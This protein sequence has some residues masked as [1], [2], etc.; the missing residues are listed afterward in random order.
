MK[1]RYH[2]F[3]GLAGKFNGFFTRQIAVFILVLLL[4]PT[5]EIKAQT[6]AA[7]ETEARLKK[8]AAKYFDEGDF[9]EAYPLYSQL[10]S[11]YPRD[12]NY[13]Y[14]FG[15]CML[16]T[17]A[18]KNKAVD[19]LEFAVKQPDVEVLAYYY[20]GRALHLNYRFNEAISSYQKFEDLAP[21]SE[22]KKYPVVNYIE[23]CN[24]GRELIA[25]LR[26]LDVLR[27]KELKLSDYFEAYDMHSN[28]GYLIS[29]PDEF[30]SKIDKNKSNT[31]LIYL[32]PDKS[33][34]F[35]SSYGSNENNGKDI[36]RVKRNHNG[37]WSVPENLGDIINTTFDED[38]PVYDAPHHTLYFSSKGHNTMGG[39]DIFKSVYSD[40]TNTFSEPVNLDFPVN[41]P[42]D[43]ILFVPDSSGQTAFFSSTRSSPLGT[44][45]VYKIALHVHPPEM[46]MIAGTA[47]LDDG[48]TPATLKITV[49]DIKTDS[50][51]GVYRSSAQDGKYSFSIPNGG[52]YKFTVEDSSHKSQSQLVLLPVSESMKAVE[53]NIQFSSN[54]SV[55]I[56]TNQTELPKDSDYQLAY[57]AI[58]EQ[59]QMNVNVDTN[60]LQTLLA[61]NSTSNPNKNT[62]GGS[63]NNNDTVSGSVNTNVS[64]V[65]ELETQE[66]ALNDKETKAVDFASDKL[67][68][69]QQQQFEAWNILNS[70]KVNG[71]Q[72]NNLDSIKYAKNLLSQSKTLEEKGL[73]AYQLAAG[74]K[75]A[76]TV[77]QAEIEKK[78]TI[79]PSM[80]VNNNLSGQTQSN[81]Q[82]L[83]NNNPEPSTGKVSPGDLIRKQA[84]QVQADSVEVAHNTND[85][86][87]EVTSLQQS[88]HDFITQA[89]QATD[90][91][92]KVA[93]LHQA[94]DLTKSKQEKEQQVNDNN[95]QLQQ[96]HNEVAWLNSR[97]QKAD[98]VYI[99]MAVNRK[100]STDN[101][102]PQTQTSLQKEIDD[103]AANNN[104]SSD[105]TNATV[106]DTTNNKVVD[107]NKKNNS[108]NP[109]AINNSN[110]PNGKISENTSQPENL[111]TVSAQAGNIDTT[112]SGNQTNT[113]SLASSQTIYSST[114]PKDTSSIS[115]NSNLGTVNNSGSKSSG[116]EK[117]N[118]ANTVTAGS[119]NTIPAD[120]NTASINT[121]GSTPNSQSSNNTSDTSVVNGN[122]NTKADIVQSSG[123]RDSIRNSQVTL[124]NKNTSE[125]KGNNNS[126]IVNTSLDT[127]SDNNLNSHPAIN[128]N[129][130]SSFNGNNPSNIGIVPSNAT[131]DS[132]GN[133]QAVTNNN[134]SMVNGSNNNKDS[135][136]V[137]S[138]NIDSLGNQLAVNNNNASKNTINKSSNVGKTQLN[139][140]TENGSNTQFSN[141]VNDTSAVNGNNSIAAG[142]SPTGTISGKTETS[143]KTNQKNNKSDVN[144]F[145][146]RGNDTSDALIDSS[147]NSLVV[148]NNNTG[149]IVNGNSFSGNGNI[150]SNSVTGNSGN[151]QVTNN[152]FSAKT[153]NGNN[154][155][156]NGEDSI[157]ISQG[158][159]SRNAQTSNSDSSNPVANGNNISN[160][161]KILAGNNVVTSQENDEA[162]GSKSNN[163]NKANNKE[164]AGNSSE[165]SSSASSNSLPE[166]FGYHTTITPH[167][168]F[169]DSIANAVPKTES[170]NK[171][172]Q[173]QSRDLVSSVQ[174]TDTVTVSLKQKS[175]NYF[176]AATT[177]SNK[178]K[179]TSAKSLKEPDKNKS[180][181]LTA[182]ADSLD[183]LALQLNLKGNETLAEADYRQYRNNV[184]E[185][186][187]LDILQDTSETYKVTASKNLIKE[188]DNNYK[189]SVTQRDK[190]NNTAILT[191]KHDDIKSARQEL[192]TAIL[193]QQ[194][195]VYL[196]FQADSTHRANKQVVA[197]VG[198]D[199]NYTYPNF[200]K[201][202]GIEIPNIRADNS[203]Q[204]I[205]SVNTKAPSTV[206]Q[207]N[208]NLQTGNSSKA[209][210]NPSPDLA[211]KTNLPLSKNQNGNIVGSTETTNPI[212]TS[213]NIQ[214]NS[215]ASKNTTETISLSD[216]V[217]VFREVKGSAYSASH[218]I[219]LNPP[220]PSGLLFKVQVGAFRKP[221]PQNLFEGIEPIIGQEAPGGFIRY[222]TGLFRTFDTAKSV[223][224]KV[225]NRGYSDA[226]IIAFFNGERISMKLA[227]AKLGITTPPVASSG[228]AQAN[229]V[230]N[231][232]AI[233]EPGNATVSQ[234]NN[235]PGIIADNTI[236]PT[237]NTLIDSGSEAV[238]AIKDTVPPAAQSFKEIKGLV[239][240]VQVGSFSKHKGF[241]R[242]RKIK[243]L[244]SWDDADGTV[245][246]NSGTYK[247]IADAKAAKGII[248]ANT[249][250]KDAFI[251][252]YYNGNRISIADANELLTKG[253]ISTKPVPIAASINNT[254]KVNNKVS[255]V[256]KETG[257]TKDTLTNTEPDSS[258]LKLAGSTGVIYTVRIASYP[259]QMPVGAANKILK[260]AGEGIEPHQEKQGLTAY[261]AGKFTDYDSAN[262]L[263]Q[264]L[265]NDGFHKASVVAYYKG[266]KISVQE[267]RAVNL[268]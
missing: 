152:N 241:I 210:G 42:D 58:R 187:S 96:L 69:A 159:E 10:L 150:T 118:T 188:A 189:K 149:T 2:L 147:V 180:E 223:L 198:R 146:G 126:G 157:N 178:A 266:K 268:K 101:I 197:N 239:F 35:F 125:A 209:S 43:D 211:T 80:S 91:Q 107:S 229:N 221:I 203:T 65:G 55:Q 81:N 176:D 67:E 102:N 26:G 105:S 204:S 175:Q 231:T 38:F 109:L 168:L 257:N 36:Y 30:K 128:N 227:L 54:G 216:T 170:S 184:S 192:A 25:N 153:I 9:L 251:S 61:Q 255:T 191:I 116:N 39:F 154:N 93:L 88:S 141:N 143:T 4:Q 47:F 72:S 32:T 234:E 31:N 179:A 267:A 195:A 66:Q 83:R 142:N 250:V 228:A 21:S 155:S 265:F 68:E 131:T 37:P 260:Y 113:D 246:Y 92:Q 182:K 121:K 162:N 186:N 62:T 51:V 220:L 130:K 15:A 53:Q 106:N 133:S 145:S 193:R 160:Q 98:S 172:T 245:K 12:P 258:S 249:S 77:K 230:T 41:T 238:Q 117:V 115:G 123:N 136:D 5:L 164:V 48:K 212:T 244:Y 124:N 74:Y 78:G 196:Y 34:A 112:A 104:Y 122:N 11:L 23:M 156:N 215:T 232:G 167:D 199:L 185:I 64:T 132:I 94:D 226:F 46:V 52:K 158:N 236:L 7:H 225:R 84:E 73:E 3:I 19:Y 248:V 59:A 217:N 140:N 89:G 13:N 95:V 190:A 207:N 247:S 165:S 254:A 127:G 213:G 108:S 205:T 233:S 90:P 97:A 44:I 214:S 200:L 219:P 99:A 253:T 70:P 261:Y 6:D 14:R 171:I 166:T 222:S 85:I 259:G 120:I 163:V 111:V 151:P 114:T 63:V 134:A 24:N 28:G 57:N 18:D 86:N 144:N 224:V 237:N 103:Y 137:L 29:E 240:T 208:R 177:F 242:L 183:K 8:A 16:F 76:A 173:K 119:L 40:S 243:H 174:Y 20:L 138:T 50:I 1:N 169:L 45:D 181:R 264:K 135:N 235:K 22:S 79:N 262:A 129:N 60:N 201:T 82:N 139:G 17:N 252:A 148:N 218:P 27:K 202:H 49:R 161:P 87:Q 206:S 256:I 71:Q 75:N 194:K 100:K 56:K 263:Q 110:K 33:E